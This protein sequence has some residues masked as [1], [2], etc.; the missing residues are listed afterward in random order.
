M[1][2]DF[3][4]EVWRANV[5]D[6]NGDQVTT[7]ALQ[8]MAERMHSMKVS[9][10]FE[11]NNLVGYVKQ[12]WI[13]RGT[14]HVSATIDDPETIELLQGGEAAI[15]P[16]FEIKEAHWGTGGV[17]V[18]DEIGISFLAVSPNPMP[19]PGEQNATS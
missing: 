6:A 12:A 9:Y 3:T 8:Q 14:L 17:H 1:S 16:G 15:R 18:V 10:N 19:L 5:P 7:K 13:E 2:K 11:F 4:A